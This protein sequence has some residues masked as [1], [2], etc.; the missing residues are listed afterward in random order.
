M[1]LEVALLSIP[2]ACCLSLFALRAS[3][4]TRIFKCAKMSRG[5]IRLLCAQETAAYVS[6]PVG[7]DKKTLVQKNECFLEVPPRFELGNE[8]FADSCLTTWPRYRMK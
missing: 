5:Q 6:N 8:S 4:A 1:R 2:F 7:L 3:I